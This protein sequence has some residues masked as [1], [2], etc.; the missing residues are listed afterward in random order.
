MSEKQNLKNNTKDKNQKDNLLSKINKSKRV[1]LCNCL[2]CKYCNEYWRPYRDQWSK[3]LHTR[4]L[5]EAEVDAYVKSWCPD[6]N[7]ME[8]FQSDKVDEQEDCNLLLFGISPKSSVRYFKNEDATGTIKIILADGMYIDKRSLKPRLQNAI[9][10][11]AAYSNPQFFQ[12]LALG[13][14]T[15]ETPRI[16]YDGYDEGGYI[17]LPRGCFE[18]LKRHL[19]DAEIPYDIVD[20]RQVV[21]RNVFATQFLGLFILVGSWFL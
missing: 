21:D 17:V 10:R 9:R 5:S 3:L 8:M 20:K 19:S 14:S 11:L 12:N 15:R 7:T 2:C 1:K 6:D 18:E 13:F 4:K 16:V